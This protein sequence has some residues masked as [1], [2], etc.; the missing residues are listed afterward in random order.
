LDGEERNDSRDCPGDNMKVPTVLCEEGSRKILESSRQENAP[1]FG[2]QAV[3]D[4]NAA[5]PLE[6]EK[7]PG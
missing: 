6:M 1:V 7:R 5:L 2:P 4:G 3:P